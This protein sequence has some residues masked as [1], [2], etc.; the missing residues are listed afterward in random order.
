MGSSPNGIAAA[1]GCAGA[2]KMPE[3]VGAAAG[4]AGCCWVCVVVVVVVVAVVEVSLLL[5]PQ[6]TAN[7]STI[8]IVTSTIGFTPAGIALMAPS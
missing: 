4:A 7:A 8:T 5:P 2:A 3:A 1:E 6:A